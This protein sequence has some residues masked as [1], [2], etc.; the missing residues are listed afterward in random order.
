MTGIRGITEITGGPVHGIQIR[1]GSARFVDRG[2]E[3]LFRLEQIHPEGQQAFL[4][5]VAVATALLLYAFNDWRLYGLGDTFWY[6]ITIRVLFLS[7]SVSVGLAVRRVREPARLDRLLLFWTAVFVIVD[8]FIVSTRPQDLLGHTLVHGVL[9]L[10]IYVAMPLP[11]HLQTLSGLAF[12]IAYLYLVLATDLVTQPSTRLSLIMTMG[13]ANLL[14]YFSARRQHLSARRLFSLLA[15][16]ASTGAEAGRRSITDPLTGLLNRAGWNERL[17]A[18]EEQCRASGSPAAVVAIDLDGLKRVND[19]QG[20]AQGDALIVRAAQCLREAIRAGDAVARLGGDEFAILAASC[21]EH[22]ARALTLRVE[23][24]LTAAAVEA[25][26]GWAV[27]EATGGLERAW[28]VAD[29]AMYAR[30]AARRQNS[31]D[32]GR[33]SA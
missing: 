8:L 2:L 14:G 10:L 5:M 32:R 6:L 3:R 12:S 30:K 16:V 28:K 31:T 23:R 24:S 21:D 4:V 7:L 9:V 26:A 19:T 18:I 1:S 25:S 13:A 17:M 11:L 33:E 27:T 29:H 22:C 15:H 20:H